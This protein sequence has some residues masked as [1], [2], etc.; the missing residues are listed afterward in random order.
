MINLE[1]VIK[2]IRNDDDRNEMWGHYYYINAIKKI[3]ISSTAYSYNKMKELEEAEKFIKKAKNCFANF[4][5]ADEE[6]LLKC[7]NVEATINK[8]QADINKTANEKLISKAITIL[9]E[10]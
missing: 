1:N 6:R 10:A 2:L 9:E 7:L 3:K 8:K 4:K 5:N